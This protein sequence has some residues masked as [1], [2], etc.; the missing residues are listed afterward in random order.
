MLVSFLLHVFFRR[1]D[2]TDVAGLAEPLLSGKVDLLGDFIMMMLYDVDENNIESIGDY[3][4]STIDRIPSAQLTYQD[5]VENYMNKNKPVVI[6]NIIEQNDNNNRIDLWRVRSSDWLDESKSCPNI[7]QIKRLFGDEVVPI[8]EQEKSGF[9]KVRPRLKKTTVHQYCNWWVAHHEENKNEE[10][11]HHYH[12]DQQ[13]VQV[14]DNSSSDQITESTT[15]SCS[16]KILYLKDWKFQKTFPEYSLYPCPTYF[17]NDWLN[18]YT[19]G[20]YKFIYLGPKGSCTR[21]HSDVLCSYS[22]S[23]NICGR[24]RWYMVPPY[25]TYLLYDCFGQQHLASHL[26]QDLE[27]EIGSTFYP[28]LKLARLHAIEVIQEATETIFVPSGWHH[29]VENMEPTL[30]VNH[31]WINETNILWSWEKV[32]REIASL[33]NT[34]ISKEDGILSSNVEHSPGDGTHSCSQIEDDLYLIWLIVSKKAM[35]TLL[36]LRDGPTCNNE[37]PRSILRAIAPV[38]RG[39]KQIVDIRMVQHFKW[40]SSQCNVEELLQ[41][42]HDAEISEVSNAVSQS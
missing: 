12:Y 1:R 33:H 13:L 29:T 14:G 35:D 9:T 10:E 8:H 11:N 28:G 37:S 27:E 40:N 36:L 21:L 2:G 41:L 22:W 17:Q 5:F 30:S 4:K 15:D 26:H 31:N 34:M 42:I 24:K 38:L 6:T 39:I 18:E 20:A 3:S 19:C 25:Y 23:T 16:S 7:Q 32:S